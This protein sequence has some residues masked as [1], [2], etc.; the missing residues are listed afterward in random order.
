MAD[1]VDAERDAPSMSSD[2]V[3]CLAYIARAP[4]HPQKLAAVL[5]D[6]FDRLSLGDED[7]VFDANADVYPRAR[8]GSLVRAFDGV[9]RA[10]GVVWIAS[11]PRTCGRFLYPGDASADANADA[12][13]GADEASSSRSTCVIVA[14][15][16][17]WDVGA[18]GACDSA[19]DADARARAFAGGDRRQ[20]VVFEGRGFD[21]AKIK[22]CLDACLL[23]EVEDS[24]EINRASE[25]EYYCGST[26]PSVSE[27]MEDAGVAV[28]DA[29]QK[30]K[31]YYPQQTERK[32]RG[33][34][35]ESAATSVE[36]MKT[37]DD[38]APS[39]SQYFLGGAVGI[40]ER[41]AF[42][43][44][45]NSS[46]TKVFPNGLMGHYFPDM[47]CLECG[48]PWWFGEDWDS[49]CSNCGADDRTYGSDQRP[50]RSRRRAY[51]AFVAELRR[52]A[53]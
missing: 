16:G 52:L 45:A 8:A 14:C 53:L 25:M 37:M 43:P 38:A 18:R 3:Q 10:T 44:S 22:T 29:E 41:E 32:R 19:R 34:D 27:V 50:I 47:P 7:D 11:R 36:A 30:C 39:S 9:E 1:D 12:S 20:H 42:R 31:V 40:I 35:E 28:V 33:H 48:S 49:K 4:F 51:E 23:T 26:W 5:R 13:S 15:A 21:A 46:A 6:N 24:D 17:A 2:D